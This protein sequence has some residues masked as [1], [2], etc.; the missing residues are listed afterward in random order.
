MTR[1]MPSLFVGHGSPMN[2]IEDNAYT[3]VWVEVAKRLPKPE[4][5]LAVSAHWFT[6]GTR[7]CDDEH[8]RMEYDMYG[9]PDELYQL[10]YAAPGAPEKARRTLEL[11]TSDVR[12]DNSWG[13]DHGTWSVL[14]RLFPKADVPVFQ[15]SVDRGATPAEH[16]R[17]GR[18]IGALRDEG[19]LVLGS[20]NVVHNLGRIGWGMEG[21]HPW[22]EEFDGFIRERV[23]GR[24]FDE[25]VDYAKAGPSA[26]LAVPTTDH[27]D[28]LLYVL[29]ATRA[30]DGLTVF[31]EACMM[32]SLSMTS[33]L[34]E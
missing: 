18:E 27:F 30:E 2:A 29:G 14:D 22:A 20:G 7:V 34:F 26:R 3:K 16:F 33:Y 17:I 25:V 32:G 1:K 5:I 21:G 11:I 10:V 28:P 8:P 15:L 24:R 23:V 13:F 19:V 4:A 6:E 31:N 9:F 12:V